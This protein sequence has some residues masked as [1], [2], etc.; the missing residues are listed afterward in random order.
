MTKFNLLIKSSTALCKLFNK[1]ELQVETRK[2]TVCFRFMWSSEWSW[3]FLLPHLTSNNPSYC[4][5]YS[6]EGQLIELKKKT[7][8]F[9]KVLL[10]CNNGK[11]IIFVLPTQRTW[12]L[13]ST[14]MK[15]ITVL[16]FMRLEQFIF[17]F[18]FLIY[19]WIYW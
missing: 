7:E 6:T 15:Y 10:T 11:R 8:A 14:C 17:Y 18:Y 3:P 1:W 2:S 19:G 13:L 4:L 16:A 9:S 12:K 5:L